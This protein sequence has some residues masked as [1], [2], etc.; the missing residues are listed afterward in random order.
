MM[1]PKSHPSER[2]ISLLTLLSCTAP[3]QPREEGETDSSPAPPADSGTASALERVDVVIIGGGASGLAAASAAAEAGASVLIIEREETMGGAGYHAGNFFACGTRWQ[4]EQGIV[5]SPEIAAAEWAAF[6]GG[7]PDHAW[8]AGFLASSAETLNWLEGYG[9]VFSGVI[10]DPGAGSIPRVHPLDHTSGEIPVEVLAESLAEHAWLNTTAVA[11]RDEGGVVVGVDVQTET[12]SGW[13]EAGAVVVAT[14]GF[15]RDDDRAEAALPALLSF[16]R[17]VEAWPGMDGNGLDLIEAVGGALV[18]LEHLGTYS[19]GVTDALLGSPEVMVMIGL[20]DS[21]VVGA[22]GTRVV[23]EDDLRAPW[24]GQHTLSDGPLYA[25]LDSDTWASVTMSGLGYNYEVIEDG[26][27]SAP[28]YAMKVSVPTA[29]T[30]TQL[31]ALIEVD[32]E[33]LSQTIADY[34]IAVDTS[35]D[36]AFGKPMAGMSRID[37]PPYVAAPLVV[38]TGKSFG[39]AALDVDGAVLGTDGLPIPGLYAAGEVAGVLGGSHIGHGFSGS[40]T[41][42]YYSGRVA[43]ASAA[44][45]VR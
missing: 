13:I 18:N 43:G 25:I 3:S 23:N 33:A 20:T 35:E 6:T 1:Y 27:L 8:V 41:G 14:G 5:D 40:I 19:H 34:N 29:D 16:P 28:E 37:T 4:A 9:A 12:G 10:S 24:S 36:V 7:D 32:P 30:L 11:L 42:V 44:A 38:A 39:G 45:A 21:A 17:H 2:M 15:A 22:A 26:S 31:A